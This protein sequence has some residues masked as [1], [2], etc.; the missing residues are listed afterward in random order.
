[1]RILA[2]A[3]SRLGSRG[4]IEVALG[5]LELPNGAG[6]DALEASAAGRLFLDRARS[7]GRLASID[8][9]AAGRIGMLLGR[10]DGL[11]LAIELAAARMRVLSPAEL[12][13]RLEQRGIGAIDHADDPASSLA[14]I[15][16]WTRGLLAPGPAAVLEA[17]SVAAGFDVAMAE[18]MCPE[19]DVVE[20]LDSLISLGLVRKV[21]EAHGTSRFQV[22]EMVRTQVRSSLDPVV[23][24]RYRDRHA[25]AVRSLIER[26]VTGDGRAPAVRDRLD[27]DAD[28][29]RL[30]L[31]RLDET[32][33][34][35][36][37]DVW[38]RIFYPFWATR[39]RL[40]EGMARFERTAAQLPTPT[41]A[42]ARAMVPYA[43]NRAWVADEDAVRDAML[44]T[45]AVANEVDDRPSAV[46][47]LAALGATAVN[48]GDEAL[49]KTVL[50]A[51]EQ[52]DPVGLEP[53]L[54]MRVA[55]ARHHAAAVVHGLAHD[56]AL[57]PIVEAARLAVIADRPRTET[58]I[59]GNLAIVHL[60]RR[61]YGLATDAAER[62]V[63]LATEVA[64]PLLPWALSL[65]AMARAERGDVPG[66]LQAL[67]ACVAETIE[68]DL[69]VQTGDTLLAAMPVARAAGQGLLAARLWGAAMALEASGATSFPPSDKALA[70]FTLERVR[71]EG[72]P[73]E[74]ELA[75][76][77]GAAADPVAL[78]RSLAEHLT[79]SQDAAASSPVLRHAELTKREIEI[80]ELVGRGR[81]DGEIATA[82]FISP[83]TA[84]VHVANVK[85]KLGV[86]SRLEIALRAR[87]LGLV[88][89]AG[90]SSDAD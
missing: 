72:R 23:V 38:G 68:R 49:G 69:A 70:V 61:E 76:R 60:H 46:E 30:A 59:R 82:L 13:E 29:I 14:G 28:N 74:V 51:I 58:A 80:L 40:R 87:E 36:G 8:D 90:A 65:L 6:V 81:S 85:A 25:A 9:H 56:E 15:I 89:A 34:D 73:L 22:L 16:D 33:P 11:P 64:S 83:K 7:L 75:V 43:M 5:G 18:V 55:E 32:D 26:H 4:E 39:A 54:Q 41:V 21:G 84:S 78:L 67:E 86:S 71:R 79:A 17:A 50:G 88:D 77:D 47:V 52:I 57:H 48:E 2:T 10:L 20:A 53:L 37:L 12:L 27:V 31:D 24:D 1:M 35:A 63:E 45:L 44:R 62:S 19:I 42:L 66:A 3:R